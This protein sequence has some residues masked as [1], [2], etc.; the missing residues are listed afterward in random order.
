M[1]A[2]KTVSSS[3]SADSFAIADRSRTVSATRIGASHRT[4]SAMASEAR[5]SISISPPADP[6]NTL[7]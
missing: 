4:A 6:R 2:L 5:E 3:S 7:P 1:N